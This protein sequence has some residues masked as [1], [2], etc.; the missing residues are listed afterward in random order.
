MATLEKIFPE[1]KAFS[2]KAGTP[3]HY[4]VYTLDLQTEENILIGIA[5]LTT[6]VAPEIQGYAGPIKLMVGMNPKGEVVNVHAMDHSETPSYVLEFQE[7]LN[8]FLSKNISHGFK[9][10]Q[11]IDGISRATITSEA[12]ARS[13]EKS[14]KR[15]AI[16][17]LDLQVPGISKENKPFPMDEVFVPI[18]LFLIAVIG[19]V[20]YNSILRWVALF[21]GFLYF[22][23]IKS[24]MVSSVHIVNIALLKFPSFFQSP[25]W[26]MMIGLTIVTTCLWGM[27]YCGSLCPFAIVEELLYKLIK[28]Q[29]G[30]VPNFSNK[31]DQNARYAKYIIL[32]AVIIISFIIGNSSAASIEPFLTLFTQNATAIGWALLILMLVAAV[33]HFR[34]WCKYL[35]PVGAFLGL[36]AKRSLFKIKLEKTCIHCDLCD[37]FCPTRA[38]AMDSDQTPHIDYPECIVCGECVR[39]CPQRKRHLEKD[40]EHRD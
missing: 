16:E 22:G 34:F 26:Y 17:V 29:K 36:I 31:I 27:V 40:D 37:R 28:R 12:I 7:F 5:F 2:R 4:K 33:F 30:K 10:G 25:L 24:T 19:M 3:P 11:D 9:V 35:C 13:I 21:G 8:Q 32:A 39:K 18:I 14:L 20:T 15:V 1:A 6:D 23:V 38:I